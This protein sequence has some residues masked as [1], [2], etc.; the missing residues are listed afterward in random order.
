MK[1]NEDEITVAP[2][3]GLYE[4]SDAYLLQGDLPGVDKE[5]LLISVEKR[6]LILEGRAKGDHPVCYRRRFRVSDGI[7]AD[8]ISAELE[9]GVLSVRLPKTVASQK[10]RIEIKTA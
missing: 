9:D 5:D 7:D 4:S 8:E 6:E 2:L 10:R 3:I 1:R